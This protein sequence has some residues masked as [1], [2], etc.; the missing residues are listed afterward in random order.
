MYGY[1][2]ALVNPYGLVIIR[3]NGLTNDTKHRLREQ[4]GWLSKKKPK[5]N[6]S[7]F[8]EVATKRKKH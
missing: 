4:Y 8:N 1:P 7:D 5:Q 3:Q 6:I 2:G